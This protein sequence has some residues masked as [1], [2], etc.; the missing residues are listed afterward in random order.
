MI[1]IDKYKKSLDKI[2]PVDRFIIIVLIILLVHSCYSV[3]INKPAE[4]IFVS[5]IDVVIRTVFSSIFGYVLS[6]N[7]LRTTPEAT[8]TLKE[9]VFKISENFVNNIEE[10][11]EQFE[12]DLT[13][14]Y[15][16][17]YSVNNSDIQVYVIGIMAVT[18][19]LVL[20]CAR[21]FLTEETINQ[22]AIAHLRDICVGS[23][24]FLVGYVDVKKT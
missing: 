21:H 4:E 6:S 13:K 1:K 23:I 17:K 15:D 9:E 7:F 12:N 24:G 18:T 3:Y 22:T 8:K 10:N 14:A 20:L 19:L 5:K 16:Y 11:V 2:K